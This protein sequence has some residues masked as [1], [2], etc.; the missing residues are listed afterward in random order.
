MAITKQEIKI[1]DGCCRAVVNIF[2]NRDR[3]NR[4]ERRFRSILQG[5]YKALQ[6]PAKEALVVQRA[7]QWLEE[8][9]YA[10]R[11]EKEVARMI[12]DTYRFSDRAESYT[13]FSRYREKISRLSPTLATAF[14]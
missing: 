5:V 6:D 9:P 8:R 13:V 12:R 1:H 14:R 11:V 10:L 3:E 4:H 2:R 7:S